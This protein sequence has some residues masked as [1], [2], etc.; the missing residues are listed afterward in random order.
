MNYY[1]PYIFSIENKKKFLN[2]YPIPRTLELFVES[3]LNKT[4][5]I[6]NARNAKTLSTSHMKQCIMSE[7]RFDF[8]RELVKNVPDINVAE[9][10]A[11]AAEAGQLADPTLQS[12]QYSLAVS[13]SA[14]PTPNLGIEPIA[15]QHP[16]GSCNSSSGGSLSAPP[17]SRNG[18][19]RNFPT[20]TA[21]TA[22][23]ATVNKPMLS[24]YTGSTSSSDIQSPPPAHQPIIR[25]SPNFYTEIT[26]ENSNSV[27]HY[28]PK[29]RTQQSVSTFDTRPPKLKRVDSAP[30]TLNNSNAYLNSSSTPYSLPSQQQQ[31]QTLLPQKK[32]TSAS[33]TAQAATPIQS[34]KFDFTKTTTSAMLLQ[35]QPT[36]TS[37]E[38]KTSKTIPSL[39]SIKTHYSQPVSTITMAPERTPAAPVQQQQPVIKIDVTNNASI[40]KIDYSNID[41]SKSYGFPRVTMAPSSSSASASISAASSSNTS[42]AV[43]TPFASKSNTPMI[44]IDLLNKCNS[45]PPMYKCTIPAASTLTD[46]DED[47]DNI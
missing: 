38:Y 24:L 13:T 45:G 14:P 22:S 39:V 12:S 17:T 15:Q 43:A 30:A 28:T 8:L 5:R 32:P 46:M 27:I 44:N 36:T 10:Q 19:K 9:E 20:F 2:R 41:L 23:T 37:S 42:S 1:L 34:F 35:P 33:T 6:T 21:A 4:L 11:M 31:Q 16:N 3:L 47:Y 25:Q 26:E 18:N 29:L 40:L 7:S